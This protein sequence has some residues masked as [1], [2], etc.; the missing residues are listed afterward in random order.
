MRNFAG[1]MF[2]CGTMFIISDFFL[3][4]KKNMLLFESLFGVS[5]GGA[6]DGRQFGDHEAWKKPRVSVKM[7]LAFGFIRL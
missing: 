4:V 7:L 1:G 3:F 6:S 5:S 2:I